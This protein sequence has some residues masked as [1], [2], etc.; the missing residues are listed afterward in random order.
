MSSPG[1]AGIAPAS[2][3]EALSRL[4]ARLGRALELDLPYS[5][6]MPKLGREAAVAAVFGL[7]RDPSS[8]PSLLVTLRS[9]GMAQHQGQ[10][11]FP[12]GRRDPED[13]DLVATAL[14]ESEEE[15][16]LPRSKLRAVGM[17][18]VLNTF[19]TGYLITPVVAVLRE[20]IEEVPL[21]LSGAEIA[22]A[23]WIP[24]EQ[25]LDPAIYRAEPLAGGLFRTDA[26]Y[27]D[28]LRIWGATGA[29]LRN[30]LDRLRASG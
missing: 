19:V 16:G 29:M 20:S 1:E 12:G 7:P 15:V 30:L 10:P 2:W 21:Q 4:E 14:R 13:E 22:R 6:P 17:L 18:P 23:C 3:A 25:L 9:E 5:R 27:V 8:G 26:F 11:A 28:D 24:L